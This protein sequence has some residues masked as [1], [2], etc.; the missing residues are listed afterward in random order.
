MGGGVLLR[1]W[2][3]EGYRGSCT[4]CTPHRGA[5]M[6]QLTCLCYVVNRSPQ[7]L[8]QPAPLSAGHAGYV[9]HVCDSH[10]CIRG[11]YTT[12]AGAGK[13]WSV[14]CDVWHDPVQLRSL[15]RCGGRR[16]RV[17][18]VIGIRVMHV[19]AGRGTG[20]ALPSRI[21]PKFAAAT[22]RTP[23]ANH[24]MAQPCTCAAYL[25]RWVLQSC[26]GRCGTHALQH[27]QS[28]GLL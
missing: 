5:F 7:H 19:R 14:V 1:R 15:S 24:N 2:P 25:P 16:W 8:L 12:L 9:Q 10:G 17:S 21:A 6:P 18:G 3:T 20:R 23:T 13:C 22:D 27:T 4:R 26:S 28:P 11:L